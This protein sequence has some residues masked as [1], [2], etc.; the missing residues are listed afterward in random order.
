MTDAAR[1]AVEAVLVKYDV[2]GVWNR[3]MSVDDLAG[4]V[5]AILAFVAAQRAEAQA[6]LDA[7]VQYYDQ[8]QGEAAGPG[9]IADAHDALYDA[10]RRYR[11]TLPA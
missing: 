7:A 6:V 5:D 4:L 1:A 10:I 11:A 3:R 9:E 8:A 2:Y